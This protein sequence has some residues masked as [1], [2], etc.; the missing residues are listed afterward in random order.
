MENKYIITIIAVIIIISAIMV[1]ITNNNSQNRPNDELVVCIAA[2][3][4]EPESG[5]NPMTG[6]GKRDDP[7]I[8]STLFKYDS[9]AT[10]INDLATSYNISDD[11][12]TYTVNI[13]EGIK[14]TDESPL[15][16]EDVVFTYNKAK[17]SG[18]TTNLESLDNAQKVNDTTI[19]FT[20]NRPDSTFINKLAHVG[21]V[22]SDSYNNI[23][24]GENPIGSG[25]YKL[26]QWDK[27]QQV[28][29]ERNE[30]YYGKKP[31]YRKI[32]NV[33][34]D[35]ETA[36][37]AAKNGEID[38]VEVPVTYLNSTIDGMHTQI[39]H[40][41]DGRYLSLPVMNNTE[42]K[43]VDGKSYI[44]NDITS[45]SAIREA[46]MIG[47]NRTNISQG[48]YNGL[49]DPLYDVV[50]SSLP[51]S[52]NSSL[53]DGDITQAKEILASNGWVDSDGD[54]IVEKDGKKASFNLNY[55]S[56]DQDDQ[57]IALSVSQQAKDFGIE[58]IPQSKQW[59]EIRNI[60][61]SEPFVFSGGDLD[62]YML[63]Q[64]YSSS[65]AGKGWNNV[66]GYNN[67]QVD[68]LMENAMNIELN[69]SYDSWKE[70]DK[71]A[72]KDNPYIPLATKPFLLFVSDRVDI[73]PNTQKIYPHGGDFLGNIY[74][75]K[76]NENNT[77]VSNETTSNNT[78]S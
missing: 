66:P 61:S 45:D 50:S 76:H 55:G 4:G 17:E 67:P 44:G 77:T 1:V 21:I 69:S 19:Q 53:S 37:V 15:T 60:K 33:Y 6:W 74:D 78:T 20:L 14:F 38:V 56:N 41:I 36:F 18:E 75:W 34:L 51:W 62:P 57:I 25:P 16:A 70:V 22:P 72:K 47:I 46:L 54:G 63:Y 35:A 52:L 64:Y 27:G 26:K 71:L 10:L 28:I 2:H 73:S 65:L 59:S 11:L 24:Y 8:Q 42:E 43:T 40:S 12:K 58:I 3:G 31:Y 9:N 23:T 32:T 7:L 39:M 48:A 29:F 5:F 49:A 13:R 30:D 68:K